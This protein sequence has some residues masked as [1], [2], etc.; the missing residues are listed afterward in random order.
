[1]T[2]RQASEISVFST[3]FLDLL[4]CGMGAVII[5]LIIF[6]S[7]IEVASSDA[8]SF[9]MVTITI[10][11]AHPEIAGPP[12]ERLL[13]GRK[14]V[15]RPTSSGG[16]EQI[17]GNGVWHALSSMRPFSESCGAVGSARD[18]TVSSSAEQPPFD[19]P[20]IAV[21]CHTLGPPNGA[22]ILGTYLIAVTSRRSY[23]VLLRDLAG[24]E[25]IAL[26][27]ARR[28]FPAMGGGRKS[29]GYQ[30]P[31]RSVCFFEFAATPFVPPCPRPTNDEWIAAQME[32][33]QI[34]S[35]LPVRVSCQVH[36]ST[37]SGGPAP[38]RD[39]RKDVI[40]EG[41]IATSSGLVVEVVIDHDLQLSNPVRISGAIP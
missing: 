38:S 36:A 23:T 3:S 17:D 1:M 31:D 6:L 19:P 28:P 22:P 37:F 34:V 25:R 15:V 32:G 7:R 8:T 10:E 16:L 39:V 5:L 13:V 21:D 24:D 18:C 12:N 29:I 20:L 11:Y 33:L 4:S 26:H 14:E 35:N 9:A 2:R 40:N 30:K 41:T 27:I